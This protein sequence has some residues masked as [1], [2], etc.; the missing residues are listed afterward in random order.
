VGDSEQWPSI[1]NAAE[2]NQL[3]FCKALTGKTLFSTLYYTYIVTLNELRALLKAGSP[4]GHTVTPKCVA[5][6]EDGAS[7]TAATRPLPQRRRQC[8]L[9]K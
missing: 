4:A 3:N 6:W 2:K 7:K 5:S 8:L 9:L 1:V